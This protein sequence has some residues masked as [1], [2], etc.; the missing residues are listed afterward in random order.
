MAASERWAS[1]SALLGSGR[2]SGRQGRVTA[3]TPSQPWPVRRL[4]RPL[5]RKSGDASLR[6]PMPAR[7]RYTRRGVSL[8][9]PSPTMWPDADETRML[10]ERVEREGPAAADRLWERHREPLRRMIG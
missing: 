3:S 7:R 4:N 1:R 8:A 9:D 6:W 5:V 10:L 2:V